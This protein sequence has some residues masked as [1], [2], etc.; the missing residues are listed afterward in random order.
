MRVVCAYTSVC[1]ETRAALQRFSPAP[2]EYVDVGGGG[3][4]YFELLAGLWAA[5]Q[6]FTLIEHDIV[7]HEFVF[8][9]FEDCPEPWCSFPYALGVGVVPALGCTRFRRELLLETV[10]LFARVA[11]H[12]DAVPARDWRRLDSRVWVELGRDPHVHRP[13]VGHLKRA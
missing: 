3:A 6:S 8:P 2:V 5:N 10:D 1:A 13:P 4:A 9:V 12:S 11:R 7:V